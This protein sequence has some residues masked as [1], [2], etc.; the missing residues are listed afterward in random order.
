MCVCCCWSRSGGSEARCPSGGCAV[1]LELDEANWQ[2]TNC[3]AHLPTAG[4]VVA[5]TAAASTH[6]V[7]SRLKL[8]DPSSKL[9]ARS[10]KLA[11]A[12]TRRAC[13]PAHS[14]WSALQHV[15]AAACCCNGRRAA[16]PSERAS[17]K[18]ETAAGRR[19]SGAVPLRSRSHCDERANSSRS[20]SALPAQ[21]R[22]HK[23][24]V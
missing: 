2:L 24:R 4:A 23:H 1:P 11:R 7:R 22:F 3:F 8:E 21:A 15:A 20:V 17:L 19:R 13:P 12:K 6:S 10:S 18:P 16:T 9:E 14:L 5:A